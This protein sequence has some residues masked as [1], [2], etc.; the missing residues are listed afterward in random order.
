[1]AGDAIQITG[2]DSDVVDLNDGTDFKLLFGEFGYLYP[3]IT[4]ADERV[5]LE[6]GSRLRQTNVHARTIDIPVLMKGTDRADFLTNMRSFLRKVDPTRGDSVIQY[7]AQGVTRLLTVRYVG[8]LEGNYKNKQAMESWNKI[9]LSFKAF[10]PFWY[11]TSSIVNEY[12]T[13]DVATFFPF[14]PLTLNASQVIA[15]PTIDN[16]GDVETWPIWTITGPASDINL[17]NST[18]GKIL[19][20][21]YTLGEAETI[22]IDTRPDAKTITLQDGTNLFEYLSVTSALWSLERGEND[23]SL[24]MAGAT[25]DSAIELVYTPRYWSR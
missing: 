3:P 12:T 17:V 19:T 15:N 9:V 11:A 6:P 22:V 18:T 4:H 5:P 20:L 16:E 1:M 10:D 2:P 13:S 14:F 23:I 21:T 24:Q 8:G 7:S 25:A